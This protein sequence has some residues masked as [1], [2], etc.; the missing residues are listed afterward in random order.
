MSPSN[1]NQI[2]KV[3]RFFTKTSK[4]GN[5]TEINRLKL[6]ANSF[7]L[8]VTKYFIGASICA[9]KGVRARNKR[10]QEWA[11]VYVS[12]LSRQI[13]A[14]SLRCPRCSSHPV[15]ACLAW[16]DSFR[17]PRLCPWC[18]QHLKSSRQ[19]DNNAFW[20]S[21]FFNSFKRRLFTSVYQIERCLVLVCFVPLLI[22][23]ITILFFRK[24]FGL[25]SSFRKFLYKT[26]PT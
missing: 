13:S 17:P 21:F 4:F 22:C 18:R 26:N 25:R 15:R 19:K 24:V 20:I 3:S 9:R 10:L 8:D 2:S 6:W 16:R 14:C 1:F 11:V 7:L 12:Y 23:F 5:Y